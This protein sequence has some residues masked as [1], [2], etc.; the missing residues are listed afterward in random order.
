[1]LHGVDPRAVAADCGRA[2]L[3]FVASNL[4]WMVLPHHKSDARRLPDEPAAVDVLGKQGLQPGLYRFPW[5][6][7]MAEMKDP[8]FVAKLNRGPVGFVTVTPSG[9]FNMGRAMGLWIAYIVVIG[10]CVAYLT[11][12]CCSPGLTTSRSSASR[13]RS[14]SWPTRRAV[15]RG[16]LVGQAAG[17]RRQG[18]PRRPPLRPP[19]RR[20]FRLALAA[21]G[22]LTRSHG[23]AC[24]T[25]RAVRPVR[26]DSRAASRMRATVTLLARADGSAGATATSPRTT[27][28]R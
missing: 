13:G 26:A 1:M 24:G 19:H 15:P 25:S 10:V 21:V 6:N 22:D 18:G 3:V 5:S 12:R 8:A 23:R 11:G 9:P 2:V 4:V 16:H 27:A 7:S 14:P 28:A 17:R 20:R